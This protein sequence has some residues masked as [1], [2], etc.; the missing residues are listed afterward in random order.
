MHTVPLT[1]SRIGLT[2]VHVT[3]NNYDEQLHN[4]TSVQILYTPGSDT[5]LLT[6]IVLC[7]YRG[8]NR[9]P[10]RFA[11]NEVWLLLYL[12]GL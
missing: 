3:P 12:R 6:I 5:S 11:R 9:L 4:Y 7:F 10:N 2:I 8:C 1:A